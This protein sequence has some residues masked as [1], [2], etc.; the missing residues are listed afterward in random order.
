MGFN[1]ILM[2]NTNRPDQTVYSKISI[3]WGGW[4][5]GGGG[6]GGGKE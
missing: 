4:V 2:D 5:G 3:F 1:Y 6:C